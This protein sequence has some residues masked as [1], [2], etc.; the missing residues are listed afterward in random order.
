MVVDWGTTN[1]RAYWWRDGAIVHEHTDGLGTLAVPAGHWE[2][3]VA[4]LRAEHADGRHEVMLLA[5]MVGSN[6]GWVDVAY[7]DCPAGPEEIARGIHWQSSVGIVPGVCFLEHNQADVMRGEEVQ[8]VGALAAGFIPC[9][10]IVCTPGTHNKWIV[11]EDGRIR[12]FRTS[13]TG[14]LFG[15]LRQ[16][17]TLSDL[18]AVPVTADEHYRAGV[19]HALDADDLLT[20]L[21]RIR[22][23]VLLGSLPRR[24]AASMI[25]GLVIGSDIRSARARDVAVIGEDGLANLYA[26]AIAEAGGRA[27]C[28]SG[29]TAFVIGM[30][31]ILEF[32]R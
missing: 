3:A 11:V 12:S 8:V 1:R 19:R 5:G 29:R 13:M 23:R 17:S 10:A 2:K 22:A 26:A 32:S 18:L 4:E 30:N 9:S 28:I 31:R 7:V 21:F 6:R 27:R 14:E 24:H 16:Y 25:S 20:S 15:L